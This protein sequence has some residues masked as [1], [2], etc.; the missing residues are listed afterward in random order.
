M[1]YMPIYTTVLKVLKESYLV[2]NT[3]LS[4]NL[5]DV[6]KAVSAEIAIFLIEVNVLKE[7]AEKVRKTKCN[8]SLVGEQVLHIVTDISRKKQVVRLPNTLT[9]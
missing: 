3:Y 7:V 6:E 9:Q 4:K 8:S 5:L 2:K 1:A